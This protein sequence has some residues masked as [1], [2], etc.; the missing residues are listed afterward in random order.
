MAKIDPQY[1]GQKSNEVDDRKLVDSLVNIK[2]GPTFFEVWKVFE[3]R[4]S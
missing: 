2:N 4:A 3:E 1:R